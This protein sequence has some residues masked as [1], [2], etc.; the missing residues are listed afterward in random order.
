MN[1]PEFLDNFSIDPEI[2]REMDQLRCAVQDMEAYNKL[3]NRIVLDAVGCN[4]GRDANMAHEIVDECVSFRCQ[5]D[6]LPRFSETPSQGR[7]NNLLKFWP[8]G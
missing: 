7:K 4:F 8:W 1:K 5:P 2:L 3:R 6:E